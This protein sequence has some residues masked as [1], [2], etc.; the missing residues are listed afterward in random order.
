MLDK[1]KILGLAA[2]LT[3]AS[4]LETEGYAVIVSE[5]NSRLDS[6]GIDMLATKNGFTSR[7]QVKSSIDAARK[8]R[9]KFKNY[10]SRRK[11]IVLVCSEKKLK[12][13]IVIDFNKKLKLLRLTGYAW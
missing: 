5:S 11:I 2:E 1:S 12:E 9:H 10:P 4:I 7:I 8:W 6:K 13:R 3:V